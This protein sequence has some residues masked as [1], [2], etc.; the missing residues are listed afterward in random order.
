[1]A[2]R[3]MGKVSLTLRTQ[4]NS[5]LLVVFTPI[6]HRVNPKSTLSSTLSTTTIYQVENLNTT[7][8]P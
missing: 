5:A 7:E 4:L 6:L 3:R 8:V 1:M 2:A